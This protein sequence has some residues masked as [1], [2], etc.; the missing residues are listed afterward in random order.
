MSKNHEKIA[1]T[2]IREEYARKY[3]GKLKRKDEQITGLCTR[4]D[5]LTAQIKRLTEKSALDQV[6]IQR[7][8]ELIELLQ[9][10]SELS[11]SE[12]TAMREKLAL[13]AKAAAA[14][15]KLNRTMTSMLHALGAAP[16]MNQNTC[17][18]ACSILGRY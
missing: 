14:A 10:W 3:A 15:N 8:D 18:I 16:F 9:K 5:D 6:T 1:R 2:R 17:D 12:L 4:V 11:D 13:D 7:Q